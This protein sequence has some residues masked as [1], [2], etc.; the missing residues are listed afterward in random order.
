MDLVASWLHSWRAAKGSSCYHYIRKAADMSNQNEQGF[1]IQHNSVGQ[2]SI[3]SQ[4]SE[5]ENRLKIDVSGHK[6]LQNALDV[7]GVIRIIA[8]APLILML[9]GL[10]YAAAKR[11]LNGFVQELSKASANWFTNKLS[12]IRKNN[13]ITTVSIAMFVPP[14]WLSG[15]DVNSFGGLILKGN[16][17]D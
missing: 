6:V 11:F 15:V 13:P 10:S 1:D 17:P 12:N 14:D 4:C 7:P 8:D 9:I 2:E 16:E 3:L 5:I